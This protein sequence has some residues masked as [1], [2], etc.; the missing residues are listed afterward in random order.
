MISAT[1]PTISD[2]LS[3][4]GTTTGRG[5]TAY[6][7][8]DPRHAISASVVATSTQITGS[9][10]ITFGI[11]QSYLHKAPNRDGS[12]VVFMSEN[13]DDPVVSEHFGQLSSTNDNASIGMKDMVFHQYDGSGSASTD[14][15]KPIGKLLTVRTHEA[16]TAETQLSLDSDGALIAA[17]NITAFSDQRLKE[18]IK[19]LDGKKVLEMRGVEFTKDGEI[20]SGVIAQ[21]LEK[22]APELVS[23]SG[24]YKSVAYGNLVGYLIE[25]VKDLQKQVDELK[26]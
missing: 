23:N 10:G 15:K 7:G 3:L 6:S 18:N 9:S 17:G 26:K 4:F 22:V 20:G 1:I 5:G 2:N 16:G 11:T 25:A 19:T 13:D 24:E 8:N 21:E 12:T 14:V